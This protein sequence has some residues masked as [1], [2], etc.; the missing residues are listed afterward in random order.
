MIK[1][2]EKSLSAPIDDYYDYMIDSGVHWTVKKEEEIIGYFSIDNKNKL[3][4]FFLLPF[5]LDDAEVV[6]KEMIGIHEIKEAYIAT[7]NL[8]FLSIA[9]HL[10][11]SVEINSYLFTSFLEGNQ[12][13]HEGKFR[14]ATFSDLD[15]LVEFNEKEVGAP[16]DWARDYI[17]KWIEREEYFVLKS[18]EEILGI[19]EVRTTDERPRVACL[20]MVVSSNHRR[21]GL[22][23]FLLGKAKKIALERN[24]EPI[25][26]CDKDNI[27]SLKAIQANGFR[28]KHQMLKI[29]FP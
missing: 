16:K 5:W 3:R 24:H 19:C 27:G 4:Q 2:W 8:I 29:T 10:Q 1:E 22:G 18:E 13:E 25:C 17:S 6:F 23:T 7:N 21:K 26:S 9:M 11:E 12:L 14:L 28:A 20:G 15:D